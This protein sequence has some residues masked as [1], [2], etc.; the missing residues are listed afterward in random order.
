MA[1]FCLKGTKIQKLFWNDLKKSEGI[2][3]QN[4][5]NLN[6]P[7]CIHQNYIKYFLTQIITNFVYIKNHMTTISNTISTVYMKYNSLL[8]YCWSPSQF[9]GADTAYVI[10]L[11]DYNIDMWFTKV[12][13]Q[14]WFRN[15]FLIRG[16]R[17]LF[18]YK[19]HDFSAMKIPKHA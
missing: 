1:Y 9:L 6:T 14:A 19:V 11:V 12:S 7:F 3:S 18:M 16:L 10:F 5:S 4:C 15:K 17:H 13:I 8:I 2:H